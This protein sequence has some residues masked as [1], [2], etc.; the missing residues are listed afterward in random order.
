MSI[1]ILL[2][3]ALATTALTATPAGAAIYDET[4]EPNPDGFW[5]NVPGSLQTSPTGDYD[6]GPYYYVYGWGADEANLG[7]ARVYY[8]LPTLPSGEH[9]YNV[10]AWNPTANSNTWH[11]LN[12]NAD[13]SDTAGNS[14]YISWP[15]QFGTNAQWIAF[16]AENAPGGQW[17]RLG[18]G[19]QTDSSAYGGQAIHMNPVVAPPSLYVKYQPF[20]AGAIAFGAVRVVRAPDL[21]GDVNFDGVVDIF[22]INLVSSNWEMGPEGDA[23]GDLAVDIFDIN[24]ISANW[25]ATLPPSS[26]T[27]VPEPSTMIMAALG[28]GALGLR[29]GRRRRRHAAAGDVRRS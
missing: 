28:F 3:A 17:I 12:V 27:P 23:N 19:P 24:M 20:C 16:D 2:A 4:V 18:P 25:G 11:I 15:G 29:I 26:A 21:P 1:R 6:D 22:D 14:Q 9:L 8:N 10:Y 5:N 7:S 13:G